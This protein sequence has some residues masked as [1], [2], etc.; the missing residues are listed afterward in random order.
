MAQLGV[1]A[2]SAFARLQGFAFISGRLLGEVAHDVVVRLL[3]FDP[4]PD[5]GADLHSAEPTC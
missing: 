3:R 4:D 2:R 5:T 1:D